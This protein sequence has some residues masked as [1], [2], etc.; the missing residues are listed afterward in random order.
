MDI[1]YTSIRLHLCS[2]L[3]SEVDA[4][5]LAESSEARELVLV[6]SDGR[7]V[8]ERYDAVF[9]NSGARGLVSLPMTVLSQMTPSS[10]T[11]QQRICSRLSGRW[12][13]LVLSDWSAD[14]IEAFGPN[15]S[16]AG[17]EAVTLLPVGDAWRVVRAS[18]SSPQYRIQRYRSLGADSVALRPTR[19]GQ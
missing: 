12:G 8:M 18:K 7:P 9:I 14:I 16:F 11:R 4:A 10:P 15:D 6:Y 1:G 3:Q 17:E 5:R 19:T 2:C 13:T